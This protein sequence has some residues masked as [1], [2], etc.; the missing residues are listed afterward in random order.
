MKQVA[1]DNI[2]SEFTSCPYEMLG[3]HLFRHILHVHMVT[4]SQSNSVLD[5][6]NTVPLVIHPDMSVY[7]YREDS[8]YRE[9]HS[10]RRF[11]TEK[12]SIIDNLINYSRPSSTSRP[13]LIEPGHNL[14]VLH[15]S[16]NFST[17]SCILK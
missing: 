4:E 9:S 15:G 8:F 6:C 2:M 10:S 17:N 14:K 16:I 11:N 3:V 5:S 13:A 7:K 1:T 12:A